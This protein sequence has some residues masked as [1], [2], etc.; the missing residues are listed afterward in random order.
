MILRKYVFF[1]RFLMVL[2]I[3]KG[4]RGTPGK[5]KIFKEYHKNKVATPKTAVA[6]LQL[7]LP[8]IFGNY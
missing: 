6:K 1:Q 2:G 7:S 5:F 4:P 3:Q 8:S